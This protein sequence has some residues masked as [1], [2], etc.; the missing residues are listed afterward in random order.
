MPLV[1]CYHGTKARNVPGI[2]RDG[3]KE[4]TYFARHL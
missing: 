2:V 4:G 3:F 1:I